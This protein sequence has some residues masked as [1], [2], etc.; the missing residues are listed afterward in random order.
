MNQTAQRLPSARGLPKAPRPASP[1]T[2]PPMLSPTLPSWAEEMLPK[3]MLSP[4]LPSLFDR[5]EV[6]DPLTLTANKQ[7][8][9]DQPDTLVQPVPNRPKKSRILESSS[10]D[11]IKNNSNLATGTKLKAKPSN[12]GSGLAAGPASLPSKPVSAK[13]TFIVKLRVSKNKLIK[14]KSVV[15]RSKSELPVGL[16]ITPPKTSV[17]TSQLQKPDE[18]RTASGE[19]QGSKQKKPKVS[20]S[21][22]SSS[23]SE[24]IPTKNNPDGGKVVSPAND[25]TS[26]S[27]NNRNSNGGSNPAKSPSDDYVK[28]PLYSPSNSMDKDKISAEQREKYY[29][30]LRS[31]MHNWIDLAREKK[32]DSD[33]ATKNGQDRL[34]CIVSM[35]SLFAFIIGF[36]YEDRA[37]LM[38]KKDPHSNSWTTLIPYTTRLVRM[39]ENCKVKEL[40]GLAYNIRALI[41]LRIAGIA[42]GRLQKTLKAIKDGSHPVEDLK[43]LQ[44]DLQTFSAKYASSQESV[45]SD[46]RRASQDLSVDSIEKKFPKAWQARDT[47]YSS[48]RKHDGGYRPTEDSYC[49]P[50]HVFS[51]LQDGCALGYA[52][53]KEWADEQNI[54]CEWAVMN[55]R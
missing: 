55:G 44:E 25:G 54:D 38:I 36:D 39:F 13:K 8:K 31:K 10:G 30:L 12:L 23:E 41:H 16:G 52:I 45:V 42:H 47:A 2:L 19:L 11:S 40:R 53:V 24:D 6:E 51:S 14:V 21:Y 27:N 15:S 35:D 26:T 9:S 32:H 17:R 33:N 28:T 37:E 43:R 3:K 29:R 4:T 20:R 7:N 50:L 46:F 18:K 5:S 22:S 49:F 34:A 48:L 1:M